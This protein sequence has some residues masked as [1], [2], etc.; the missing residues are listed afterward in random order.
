MFRTRQ[1]AAVLVGTAA[2]LG[3]AAAHAQ[4]AFD[5][6]DDLPRGQRSYCMISAQEDQAVDQAR[7]QQ[8]DVTVSY[9]YDSSNDTPAQAQAKQA[10]AQAANA[11]AELPRGQRSFC[12][13]QAQA[14][15]RQAM[16]Q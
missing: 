11:C 3:A 12:M 6:C 1:I 10:Y 13:E 5:A 2:M 8:K 9:D 15:Y 14:T 4:T 7:S 16:G